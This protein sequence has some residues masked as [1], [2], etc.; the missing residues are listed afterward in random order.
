MRR[1]TRT[2]LR[3]RCTVRRGRAQAPVPRRRDETGASLIMALMA[4]TVSG[5]LVGGL[6]SWTASDLNNTVH[7][8]Q[9]RS[10]QFA[11][12]SA[13]HAAVQSIRYSPLLG[14]GQTLNAS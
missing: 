12:S 14:V 9:S 1:S 5:L 6:A 13:T 4:L 7:F 3:E 11:L 10:A 2:G 8:N